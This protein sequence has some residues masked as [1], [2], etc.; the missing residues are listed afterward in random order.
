MHEK[1]SQAKGN[2]SSL[3]LSQSLNLSRPY[4]WLEEFPGVPDSCG[5]QVRDWAVPQ[6]T[7]KSVV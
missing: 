4:H 7:Q 6:P 5:H 1:L 3:G 2:S